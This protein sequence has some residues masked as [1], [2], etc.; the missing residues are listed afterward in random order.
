MLYPESNSQ[1][2]T[3]KKAILKQADIHS[4]VKVFLKFFVLFFS[5]VGIS[6]SCFQY[7][8]FL[9]LEVFHWLNSIYPK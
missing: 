5:F 8:F 2:D 3:K 1:S 7:L 9:F 6:Y 4:D